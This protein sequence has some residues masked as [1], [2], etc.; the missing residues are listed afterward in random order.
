MYHLAHMFTERN[1][2]QGCKRVPENY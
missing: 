1:E 2:L